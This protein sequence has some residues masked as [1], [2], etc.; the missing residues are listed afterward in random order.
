MKFKLIRNLALLAVLLILVAYTFYPKDNQKDK[1]LLEAVTQSMQSL[2]FKPAKF[3]DAFSKKVYKMFI[4]RLDYN[5]KFFTATDIA[6]FSQYEDKLDEAIQNGSYDFFN[7]VV[8]VFLQRTA[9]AD[10]FYKDI[11]NKP[12]NYEVKEDIELDNKKIE[13]AKNEQELKENWRK[14]LKYL[15]LL[16]ISDA[17]DIQEKAKERKDTIIKVKSFDKIE[18]EARE[19]VRKSQEEVFK[20]LSRVERDD[21][22]ALFINSITNSYDPHSEYF[23]PKDKEDFDMR[24]SGRLEGIGATLQEKDGYIKVIDIVPGSP[25]WRQGQLRSGD[26]ILK[27]AQGNQEPVDI[28]DWRVDKAV[29]LIRGSKGTEVRLTVKKVDG[30][31]VVIPIIRDIVIIEETYVKSAIIRDENEQNPIGY[32]Y[33]PQFYADFNNK[34]GHFCSKDVEL[35]IEKLKR[36]NVEGIVLDLRNNGGG[37]L[38]DV[39]SMAGLFIPNGPIVQVKARL[40]SP[41]ILKDDDP[42]VQWDKPLV[43]MVNSLSASASEIFAAAIQDY[44]RGVVIGSPTFGKGTVQR[45]WDFDDNL[46]SSMDNLKPLGAIK[47]TIQKFYR[48]NGGTTQLKGVNPDIIMPDL[49]SGIEI[50]EREQD[51][52]MAWDEIPSVGYKSWYMPIDFKKLEKN[53]RERMKN[54]ETFKLIADESEKRSKQSKQTRFSLNLKD[55]RAQMN[56]YKEDNAKIEKLEKISTGLKVSALTVDIKK[57][58]KDSITL[59]RAKEWVKSITKD[60]YIKEAKAIIKDMK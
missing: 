39:V 28:V 31:I 55:F 57:Q 41:H 13:Y 37:S 24:M 32:I 4:E 47:I 25:S 59:S 33:L 54:N 8:K 46:P 38:Q 53:S 16:R 49:F 26:L 48:I 7:L 6:Q 12:F 15:V 30:S 17:L 2:H 19:N 3:D 20:R 18:S 29:K 22:L 42:K 52:A 10:G 34:D 58:E 14:Q 35:E 56:K 43:V 36:E 9:M 11:L 45:F 23:P 44:K 21:E 1:I 60:V 51:N 5:K 50:G 27:V 40:G